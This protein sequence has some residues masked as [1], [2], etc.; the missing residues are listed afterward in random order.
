VS[1]PQKMY[2]DTEILKIGQKENQRYGC[3]EIRG[4]YK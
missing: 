4:F 3:F 2:F 1:H